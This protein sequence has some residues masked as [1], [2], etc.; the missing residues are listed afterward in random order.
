MKRRRKA[1]SVSR[2]T[3]IIESA[4]TA[5]VMV[6]REGRILLLNCEAESLF[7]YLREDLFGQPVELLVPQE[8][9]Q[10]HPDLRAGF[11]RQPT[12]RRIG[13][14]RDLF[15]VHRDG[16][17]FPVEIGLN[18]IE[19][20]EGLFVLSVIVDI[21]ER[22]R[23]ES[24]LVQANERLEHRVR[25]RTAELARQTEKIRRAN[26][27]LERSNLELQRFARIISHDLQSPLRSISGFL[28]LLKLEYEDKLDQQADDWIRRATQA[29]QQMHAL[30][31]DLLEYSRVDSEPRPFQQVCFISRSL[32]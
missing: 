23:L 18:P 32:A 17:R 28:Q 22:K 4:P 20:D 6:D 16:S 5:M 13:A 25:D 7:G 15:G 24:A 11:F 27:A 19:T 21:T 3:S 9:R 31:R 29:T 14:G 1:D 10:R 2:L 26:E 12:P 8:F 30:I